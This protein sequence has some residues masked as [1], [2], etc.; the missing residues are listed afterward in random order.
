[1]SKLAKASRFIFEAALADLEHLRWDLVIGKLA[2]LFLASQSNSLIVEPAFVRDEIKGGLNARKL[3][4]DR[5][6]SVI[7]KI[8]TCF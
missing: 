5:T 8:A 4:L 1:M 3:F 6:L 7:E 2:N